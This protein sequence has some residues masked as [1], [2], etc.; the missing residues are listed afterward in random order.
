M[1][2]RVFVLVIVLMV[3]VMGVMMGVHRRLP[4]ATEKATFSEPLAGWLRYGNV[5]R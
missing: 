2:V 3:M 1:R 5:A 4:H